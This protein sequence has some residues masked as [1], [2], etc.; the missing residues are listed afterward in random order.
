MKNIV[1]ILLLASWSLTLQAQ[2]KEVRKLHAHQGVSVATNLDVLYVLSNRN[3]IVLDCENKEHLNMIDTEVKNG[4]LR[5]QYKPNTKINSSRK[6]KVI[7]YSN[8]KLQSLKVTSNSNLKVEAPVEGN[9]INISASSSGKLFAN[10]IK[11]NTINVDLSSSAQL[12]ASVSTANLNVN[13][14][15]AGKMS[16]AGEAAVANIDMSSSA[17]LDM[18]KL[19]IKDLVC[20]GSSSAK[21]DISTA[22]T[23][24]SNLSSSAKISYA[25]QPTQILENKT[26][27]SGRLVKKS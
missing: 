21:L 2:H 13:A 11:A 26:S 19:A 1:F 25:T 9:T 23:L 20:K 5:I 22:N 24:K 7:V 15:S 27:S 17:R 4:V 18:D 16:L 8:S 14:S 12:E 6:N 3:E 10:K